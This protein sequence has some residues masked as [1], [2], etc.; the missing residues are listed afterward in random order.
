MKL[1][2]LYEVCMAQLSEM[3]GHR[4]AECETLLQSTLYFDVT[5]VEKVLT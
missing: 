3:A 5:L 2:R 4:S 1:Q